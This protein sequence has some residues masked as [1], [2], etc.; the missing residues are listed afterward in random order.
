MSISFSVKSI[1]EL[2]FVAKEI[3]QHIS[4]QV[5]AFYGEMGVGKTTLITEICKVF[6]VQ[7][8][9]SS[10]TYSIVNEYEAKD[11]SKIYHFDFYRIKNI[12]EAYD[13]GYEEYFYSGYKCFVEWPEKISDLLPNP[14]VKI[15]ITLENEERKINMEF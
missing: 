11:G 3:A 2:P 9:I 13:L 5:V 8:S 6:G 15:F 12:S 14:I 4:N 10:P 7:D 1:D